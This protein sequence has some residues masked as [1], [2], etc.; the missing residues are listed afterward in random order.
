MTLRLTEL[1]QAVFYEAIAVPRVAVFPLRPPNTT[2]GDIR[3]GSLFLLSARSRMG[4]H[5]WRSAS[6]IAIGYR[7]S[8]C[9]DRAIPG[10]HRPTSTCQGLACA[11]QM[12]DR[13]LGGGREGSLFI[14]STP[15]CLAATL[16]SL[17]H[18]SVCCFFFLLFVGYVCFFSIVV[19]VACGWGVACWG[20][21]APGRSG[22]SRAIPGA[23]A[24]MRVICG[25]NPVGHGGRFFQRRAACPG[26]SR[27]RGP[28]GRGWQ[29]VWAVKTPPP[30]A[31]GLARQMRKVLTEA[32][33]FCCGLGALREKNR[34][35]HPAA[36]RF[37]AT[38]VP[39]WGARC[40]PPT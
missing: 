37:P 38:S 26:G 22:H 12:M 39:V 34:R 3:C 30:A 1:A 40:P 32:E 7:Y 2:G 4:P 14:L 5:W 31:R 35:S 28:L 24:P 9:R 27:Q 18:L 19:S 33:P 15:H 29:A 13:S 21:E 17:S 25:P 10:N 8:G 20:G 11:A 6:S 16:C 23:S 36:D